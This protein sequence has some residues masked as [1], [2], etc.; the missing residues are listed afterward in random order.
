MKKLK[1]LLRFKYFLI[2]IL[3]IPAC[4]PTMTGPSVNLAMYTQTQED[5][6]MA[7]ILPPKYIIE[8]KTP[9]IAILEIADHSGLT[10]MRRCNLG[11]MATDLLHNVIFKMGRYEV[12]E[13]AQ[14]KKLA[15]ELGY[16]ETHGVDWEEIE[17]KYFA[18]GKNID[19]VIVGS[20][21]RVTPNVTKNINLKSCIEEAE[22]SLSLR[23]INL[24]QGIT[25]A[26]FTV[27]EK[28]QEV[29]PINQYC[30]VTCGLVQ[31][32]L[33]NAISRWVPVKVQEA[34][35]IYGYISKVMS[36]INPEGGKV[37][38][39][40]INLGTNDG[41]KPG[42][43]VIIMELRKERDL[44]TGKEKLRYIDLGKATVAQTGLRP[45]EAII[46]IDDP[47]LAKR[48]KVGF[49]VQTTAERAL[50]K[51]QQEKVMEG[52]GNLFKVLINS[53]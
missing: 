14:A 3:L 51:A 23:V 16:E 38:I 25:V 26:S 10:Q 43:K 40:Y 2:F 30:V 34:I 9:R 21:N 24:H 29:K 39:A 20:I 19:Y 22:V 12:V 11:P 28:T 13:R 4:T 45:D 49:V 52:I 41:L 18:L 6:Q 46:V 47:V 1:Y 48:V 44:V 36:Y 17:K 42:D 8:K 53:Q 27:R 32:A 35:P 50:L 15:A 5:M 37:K 33:E 31:K 7:S